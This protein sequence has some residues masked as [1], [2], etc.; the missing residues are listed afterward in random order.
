MYGSVDPWLHRDNREHR[1]LQLKDY[2]HSC[3]SR[4]LIPKNHRE[5]PHTPPTEWKSYVQRHQ[6]YSNPVGVEPEYLTEAQQRQKQQMEE[7][8]VDEAYWSSV[9]MLYQ[10]IPSCARPRP[11]RVPMPLTPL[12]SLL[13]VSTPSHLLPRDVLP[14]PPHLSPLSLPSCI[15]T[16]SYMR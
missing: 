15:P 10:K 6:Q 7:D 12:S 13:P 11:V 16:P 5:Y 8:E 1:D 9:S 3:D 14:S 4:D 2:A